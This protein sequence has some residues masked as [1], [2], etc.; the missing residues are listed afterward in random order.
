MSRRKKENEQ[1]LRTGSAIIPKEDLKDASKGEKLR[2]QVFRMVSVGVVDE[3]VNQAYDVISTIVLI[4][5]LVVMILNTFDNLSDRYGD[6]F[7]VLEH[8]TVFFFAVDY[9]LRVYTAKYLYP[10]STPVRA[11]VKYIFS[12]AGIVDVLS[13]IPFY[14]P[15]FFPQQEAAAAFI[16]I[17]HTGTYDRIKSLH[18]QC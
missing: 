16:C 17:Y 4:V 8:M 5:N 1:A 6:L 12:F 11:I 18:V 13:F 2:Y 3:P 15:V 14:L 7:T 9:M 10:D